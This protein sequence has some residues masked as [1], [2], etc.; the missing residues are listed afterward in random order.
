MARARWVG[1]VLLAGAVFSAAGCSS[2]SGDGNRSGPA[3]ACHDM[4]HAI[5]SSGEHC[6]YDYQANYNTFIG[7]AANG[8]CDNIVQIRD[9]EA[10]YQVCIP[11]LENLTCAQVEDPNLSLPPECHSQLLRVD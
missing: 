7:A 11:Y 3:Q 1:F 4:A 8:D 9:S 5:A 2:S 10:L 6:G